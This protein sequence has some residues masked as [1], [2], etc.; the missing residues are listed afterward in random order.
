MHS[1]RAREQAACCCKQGHSCPVPRGLG[2]WCGNGVREISWLGHELCTGS[3]AW[4]CMNIF[5][6]YHGN[7]LR[8]TASVEKAQEA[9]AAKYAGVLVQV[10]QVVDDGG[11]QEQSIA[12]GGVLTVSAAAHLNK[13]TGTQGRA[14]TRVNEE[15]K[16]RSER[17]SCDG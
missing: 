1:G 16:L 8:N 3:G 2:K 7:L 5:V 6:A 4:G 11:W 15:S 14:S 10:V 17:A 12:A 9:S 13:S